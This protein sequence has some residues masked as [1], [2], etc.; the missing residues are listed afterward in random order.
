MPATFWAALPCEFYISLPVL[1]MKKLKPN[2]F[3]KVILLE[4]G[5]DGHENQFFCPSFHFNKSH[6]HTE[7]ESCEVKSG[8][9]FKQKHVLLNRLS[10]NFKLEQQQKENVPVLC[11]YFAS[12]SAKA[13]L[14]P[15]GK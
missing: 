14:V 1:H 15:T 11:H 3:F 7:L 4:S 2:D 8:T 6:C 5:A 10:S 12:F 13:S 9:T